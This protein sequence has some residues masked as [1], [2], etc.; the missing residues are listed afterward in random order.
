MTGAGVPMHASLP[1]DPEETVCNF[2]YLSPEV[3]K[4][5]MYVTPADVYGFG[6][7]FY[8]LACEAKA[9]IQQRESSFK[10]FVDKLN[11][12]AMLFLDTRA[13]TLMSVESLDL[14]KKCV[15]VV[16]SR[17]PNMDIVIETLEVI[18]DDFQ[19]GMLTLRHAMPA[20]GKVFRMPTNKIRFSHRLKF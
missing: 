2:V 4:K 13:Q 10:E 5:E 11:P 20:P 14:V 1:L 15:E 8:E 6:L 12:S 16:E 9:F 18:K 19:T 17:R 7:L 3:L